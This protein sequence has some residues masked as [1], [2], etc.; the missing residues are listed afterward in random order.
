MVLYF[1]AP[2]LRRLGHI[3][4]ALSLCVSVC[5][6]V[7]QN[8]NLAS[9]MHIFSARSF[10]LHR[11]V[12]HE[13]YLTQGKGQGHGKRSRSQL[14]RG[15]GV[16]V[17]REDILLNMYSPLS[18]NKYMGESKIHLV[19]KII[20]ILSIKHSINFTLLSHVLLTSWLTLK[21]P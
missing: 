2:V 19:D 12:D 6:C 10:K 9:Q 7:S 17:F 15:R 18:G 16:Q 8:V 20:L 1:Y 5:L 11:L 14:G 21:V 13:E 4:F 3:V